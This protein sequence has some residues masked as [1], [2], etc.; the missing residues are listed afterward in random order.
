MENPVTSESLVVFQTNQ[1]LEVR[2]TALRLTKHQVVFEVCAPSVILRTSEV[3][4]DFTI[5]INGLLVYA[6]RAVVSNLLNTGI[7]VVCEATLDDAW[8]DVDFA[9]SGTEGA[10]L[11][12]EFNRFLQSWQKSYRVLPEFKL[13]IA[14][15]Q[16]YLMDLRLWLEQVE[17]GIRASPSADRLELEREVALA[18]AQAVV[19]CIDSLWDKFE[20]VAA[21]IDHEFQ[22][23]HQH[24]LRRQLHPLILSSPFAYR[25]FHKPLGYAGD[26]EMVNMIMRDPHEGCSLFAKMV[27]AWL[28]SQPPAE[29]HRNRVIYLVDK[30][31]EETVRVASE[32]KPARV[33]SLA[34]GPAIE[35]QNFFM[36]KDISDR[37]HFT[38]LD[39]NE[40]TLQYT[41]AVMKD[42][43]AKYQ[44]VT[45]IEYLKKSVHQLLKEAGKGIERRPENQ[46]DFIYCG[47]LFDYLSDSVC[48]RLVTILY[49]W[50]AP[51]GLFLATNVDSSKPFHVSMDYIL[52]W[53]LICRSGGRLEELARSG[54][55]TANYSVKADFTGVN[56]I[57]EMR[58]PKDA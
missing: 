26:Y 2:A 10:K 54:A 51:G 31:T 18:L 43:K 41:S 36:D 8:R 30:L 44:R 32:R 53:R 20:I 48:Q 1:G 42:I 11:C 24:Y 33:F 7:V 13:I 5:V 47:G 27:N 58:K 4:A 22:P 6:G 37:A 23:V 17:L 14:D 34:C 16:M 57:T 19:P 21:G 15:M 56:V 52:D 55:P 50:L 12:G 46:Y 40:E 38:L 49:G 3:L 9:A 28:L 25:T 45:P 39:F 29:A 35:V